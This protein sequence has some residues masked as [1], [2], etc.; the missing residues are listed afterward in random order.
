MLARS[1]ETNK[2]VLNFKVNAHHIYQ[3][4]KNRVNENALKMP[5]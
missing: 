1:E 4:K 2:Q 3:G 5:Y